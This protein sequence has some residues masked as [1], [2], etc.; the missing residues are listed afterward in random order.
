[1]SMIK[2]GALW[3]DIHLEAHRVLIREFLQLGIFENADED[4]LFDSNITARFFP[5]G[6]GHVL[7]MDTH[8]VGGNPNY[9]D[10]DPKLKYLRLRRKLQ[11]GMVLTDEPGVYF[12]P[13]LLAD[14]LNDPSKMKFINKEI[15][16]K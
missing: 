13:F 9:E 15:L 10:P 12:S 11:R 7:G 2:P 8:D 1:M 16:D 3:D 14:V 6:L 4:T 5:H